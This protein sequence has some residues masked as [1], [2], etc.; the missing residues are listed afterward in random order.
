MKLRRQYCWSGRNGGTNCGVACQ[1]VRYKQDGV[2]W[3]IGMYINGPSITGDSGGPVRDPR[4]LQAVGVISA[5]RAS[6]R[7]SCAAVLE[8]EEWCPLTSVT[9]RLPFYAKSYPDGVMPRLG[10]EFVRNR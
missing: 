9:P 10:V 8:D 3:T 4:T 2:K 1:R 6:V 5:H 7:K